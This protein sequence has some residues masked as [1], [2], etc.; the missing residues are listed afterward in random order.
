[1]ENIINKL[2]RH[3]TTLNDDPSHRLTARPSSKPG[4]Q[5][6]PPSQSRR[7]NLSQ[8]PGQGQG[9]DDLGSSFAPKKSHQYGKPSRVPS[10]RETH[11]ED[12]D[13]DEMNLLSSGRASDDDSNEVRP[14]T[15]APKL[16]GKSSTAARVKDDGKD[17]GTVL[18]AGER[19]TIPTQFIPKK[20]PNFTKTKS[21]PVG[22]T[23]SGS[24]TATKLKSATSNSLVSR[25]NPQ[26]DHQGSSSN[27]I[28][29]AREPTSKKN[30]EVKVISKSTS[31]TSR[32]EPLHD[33]VSNRPL[34]RDRQAKA[35]PKPRRIAK[36]AVPSVIC[37]TDIDSPV[38]EKSKK[39]GSLADFPMDLSPVANRRVEKGSSFPVSPLSSPA[40]L[41]KVDP[42]STIPPL[43]SQHYRKKRAVIESSE[44]DCDDDPLAI[45]SDDEI[46]TRGGPRPFPMSTQVLQTIG[47][48]DSPNI[49]GDSD[50]SEVTRESKRKRDNDMYV[51]N[52]ISCVDA[53]VG[54]PEIC[55]L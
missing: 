25:T 10:R 8:A 1:M 19:H 3:N 38:R 49:D 26:P 5:S 46:V 22:N 33:R 2:S 27:P 6:Q 35:R 4:S 37:D 34:S 32:V 50:D 17:P 28:S 47:K 20:L 13:S 12:S 7:Q 36:N 18:I 29:I 21:L 15:V 51:S 39:K 14:R 44:D 48:R 52:N 24:Q 55:C 16:S 30:N 54:V 31:S 53:N 42:F 9:F 43:S 45:N 11:V 41:K 23:D 40:K